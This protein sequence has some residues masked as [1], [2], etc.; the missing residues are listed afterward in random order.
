MARQYIKHHVAD[1]NS[2]MV[3]K[4]IVC[5][6]IISDYRNVMCIEGNQIVVG[7]PAGDIYVSSGNPIITTR[8]LGDGET[9]FYCTAN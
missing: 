6:A 8:I 4:C 5:G 1:M 7:F 9:S 3:Q 2:S